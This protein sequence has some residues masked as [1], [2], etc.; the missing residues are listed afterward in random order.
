MGSK[1]KAAKVLD[2]LF[3]IDI[4]AI[5]YFATTF[6]VDGFDVLSTVVI[7]VLILALFAFAFFSFVAKRNLR[8]KEL[9]AYIPIR[10]VE[11][12]KGKEVVVLKNGV[13]LYPEV[14]EDMELVD[15]DP[16][17]AKEP[18]V[19]VLPNSKINVA[20]IHIDQVDREKV[21]VRV[22]KSPVALIDVAHY[23]NK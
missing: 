19:N 13:S 8:K 20:L 11:I 5:L 18:E 12:A 14:E 1:S 21:I 17:F 16:S 10:N 23:I 6:P 15:A 2:V 3:I 9:L 4:V 22:F 7:G